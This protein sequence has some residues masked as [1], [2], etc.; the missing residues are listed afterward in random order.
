MQDH[1]EDRLLEEALGALG[2]EYGGSGGRFGAQLGARLL[3]KD[4]HKVDLQL[5]VTFASAL[6]RVRAALAAVAR[7]VNPGLVEAGENHVT[8]GAL[9]G[10]GFAALNP[11]VVTVVVTRD[12]ADGT[13]VQIRAAAK[14][15]LI[16]QHAGEK[17]TQRVADLLL[18]Q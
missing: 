1:S 17:M 12:A 11:V 7:G 2:E 4:I 16:K 5:P 14:E 13:A 6:E 9:A 8:L 15:G 10:G 18:A 3:P